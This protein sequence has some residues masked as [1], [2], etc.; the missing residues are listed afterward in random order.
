MKKELTEI[1]FKGYNDSWKEIRIKDIFELKRG[2]VVSINEISINKTDKYKY[3]VYS[4]KTMDE[5][6]IGYH[7]KYLFEKAITVTTHGAYVG[8]S[9]YRKNK[10]NTT[11]NCITFLSNDGYSNYA[12]SEIININLNNY[13]Y[14]AAIPML[15]AS[16]I[17]E[18]TINIPT[19]NE[20][21]K[22][23]KLFYN[24]DNL[25]RKSTQKYNILKK[26]KEFLLST[27]FI[28]GGV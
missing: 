4:S 19:I 2:N 23:S 27:M 1:R 21:E 22:L 3:P 20:Q 17:S 10:F 5:G 25:I 6:I 13:A 12:I 11:L 8:T 14:N 16:M 26:V 7:D 9:K 28:E 15:S 24:L 18:V